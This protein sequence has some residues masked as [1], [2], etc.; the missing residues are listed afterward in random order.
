M[1]TKKA[2]APSPW[3][4]NLDPSQM[5]DQLAAAGIHLKV[6]GVQA[7]S[8]IDPLS[9]VERTKSAKLA[10]VVIEKA[11]EAA[12]SGS[13]SGLELSDKREPFF[14]RARNEAKDHEEM[15]QAEALRRFLDLD[16]DDLIL[17]ER[18]L[19]TA[20]L[21]AAKILGYGEEY[22]LEDLIRDGLRR[23]CQ[24]MISLA[25]NKKNRKE[26][27]A[28]GFTALGVRWEKYEEAYNK[29]QAT[30]G[31][32]A[33]GFRKPYITLS[34]IAGSIEGAKSNV[35]QIRRWADAT[36]KQIVPQPGRDEDPTAGGLIVDDKL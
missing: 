28:T 9:T 15:S 3:R 13:G 26:G 16:T 8:F 30:L 24:E 7:D 20:A 27:T 4:K 5:A 32:P 10:M 21:E 14:A 23:A 11:L 2:T 17:S 6:E 34:Y 29:L 25:V 19:V 12:A 1:T 31:T 35:V 36:G 22:S 18:A 33:W